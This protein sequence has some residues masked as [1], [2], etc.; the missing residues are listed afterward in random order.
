MDAAL[1]GAFWTAL[2]RTE[3]P[4]ERAVWDWHGGIGRRDDPMASP[5]V[6]PSV[7][8]Y[9]DPAFAAFIDRLKDYSSA[10]DARPAEP[11]DMLIDR[12]E[13]LWAPIAERDDWAP[14]YEAI[15]EI[16]A[17]TPR[18]PDTPLS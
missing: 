15:R 3:A 11:I 2:T 5:S 17:A 10:A 7:S 8:P 4:F 14:L 13:A 16:E 9:R 18:R 1:T 6:S 12:V